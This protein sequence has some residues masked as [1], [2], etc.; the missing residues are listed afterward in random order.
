MSL[1]NVPCLYCIVL[2]IRLFPNMDDKTHPFTL[3]ANN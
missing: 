2:H 1:G 3:Y